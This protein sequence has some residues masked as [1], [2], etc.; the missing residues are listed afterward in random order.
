MPNP[1]VS[2]GVVV[3]SGYRCVLVARKGTVVALVG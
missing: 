1:R 3:E 2:T